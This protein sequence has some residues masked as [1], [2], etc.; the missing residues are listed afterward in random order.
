MANLRPALSKSTLTKTASLLKELNEAEL[1]AQGKYSAGIGKD[2][3]TIENDP[4]SEKAAAA[5]GKAPV[6]EAEGDDEEEKKVVEAEGDEDEEKLAEAD[7]DEE[8]KEKVVE[9]EGDDKEE[10][11]VDEAGNPFAKKDDEEKVSEGEDDDEELEKLIDWSI[12]TEEDEVEVDGDKKDL[13]SDDE[14]SDKAGDD[15]DKNKPFAEAEDEEEKKVDEGENP[16]AKKDEED[17]EKVSEAEGDDEEEKKVVEAEGDDEEEKKVVEAEGDEDEEKLSEDDEKE[18]EV[19]LPKSIQ[20]DIAVI[21]KGKNSLSESDF[22]KKASLIYE[23]TLKSHCSKLN[24]VFKKKLNEAIKGQM[25][26]LTE[27][28]DRYLDHVTTQWAKENRVA[29]QAGLVSELAEGVVRDLQVVFSNHNINLPDNKL[30]LAEQKIAETK[31][32]KKKLNEELENQ[33]SLT[34]ENKKLKLRIIK[35]QKRSLIEK[36]IKD[37]PLSEQSKLRPLME[38][39]S[40]KTKEEFVKNINQLKEVYSSKKTSKG[41]QLL[42]TALGNGSL[43]KEEAAVDSE[44]SA[45]AKVI[46][47]TV[48]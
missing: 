3:T 20:E 39:V 10:K 23:T 32:L 27:A 4:A 6:A 5:V 38:Q 15:G 44:V 19:E 7:S 36:S 45:L 34:K 31:Q 26:T 11:K 42:E 8:D 46:K 24:K 21:V 17:K 43:I 28:L 13:I 1:A 2:A 14:I 47:G 33:I 30:D 40:T 12:S 9:A 41:K 18:L 37:L 29:L 16:F 35:E 25:G 22:K 48:R